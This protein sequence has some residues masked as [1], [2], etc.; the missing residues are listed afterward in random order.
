MMP[1]VHVIVL[2]WNNASDTLECLESLLRIDYPNYQIVVCDNAS[3][4]GSVDRIRDW[5]AGRVVAP[6]VAE[7]L[8]HLM[9]TP[10]TEPGR[11]VEIDRATAE[12]G[13]TREGRA[14]RLLLVHN[15]ANLG[16]AGGNNVGMR[17]VLAAGGAR[18]A[19]YVC[20]LNNDTVV[21]REWLTRMVNHI[22]ADAGIGAAGAMLYEYGAPE[23][24]ESAGGGVV[25]S[26]QGMPR[27]T[28]ATRQRRGTPEIIPRRLDFLTGACLLMRAS[29]L[30]RTGFIDERYFMYCE[31]IDFSLRIRSLGLRLALVPDAELWHKAG[32]TM[33][34]R[35]AKHDYYLVR[36]SLLL[37]HKF[38]PAM[39][40]AALLFSVYRCAVPKLVRC[41]WARLRAV[42]SAYR[43]C[44]TF[45][46]GNT[47]AAGVGRLD[48]TRS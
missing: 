6:A 43:D 27:G 22:S 44:F 1:R 10:R 5:A 47:S 35:S 40:P 8:T 23:L 17:Y 19:S 46:A 9:T 31:D 37:V 42:G 13:G 16:F 7:P 29:T 26:W 41:D 34:H 12:S 18:D 21:S 39:L 30:E 11:L 14:A 24:V 48:A 33:P 2:N 28:T 15:G 32:G 25:K 20:L 36:N 4:D 38:Y 45:I 3:T